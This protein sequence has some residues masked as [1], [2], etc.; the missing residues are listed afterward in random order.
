MKNGG[1]PVCLTEVVED[2][3]IWENIAEFR[4]RIIMKKRYI[5]TAVACVLAAALAVGVVE[6]FKSGGEDLPTVGYEYTWDTDK[7]TV[8]GLDIEWI[9][10]SVEVGVCDGDLIYVS[11]KASRKLDDDERLEL[12]RDDGL[13][14]IKWS[15]KLFSLGIFEN[16]R[17]DLVV[18]VPRALAENME[19]FKCVTTSGDISAA[20]FTAEEIKISSTSGAVKLGDLRG[21]NCTLSTVSGEIDLKT[22]ELG[23]SLNASTTSGK[24]VFSGVRANNIDLNSTSGAEIFDGVCNEI[25]C[26]TVSGAINTEVG[27]AIER[28]EMNTVSGGITLKLPKNTGFDAEY[29]SISGEFNTDFA[30]N[31][32]TGARSGRVLCSGGDASLKFNTT[33][34]NINILRK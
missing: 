17:K 14:K 12:V 27:S 2:G 5:F 28:A 16:K 11:E 31:G 34:G 7:L 33:S 29:N 15:G 25:S 32:A 4:E 23:D 18:Q 22:A 26:S 6:V 13:L 8:Y 10:G 20:G 19:E 24:M 30:V 3:R 9:N 21:E 1:T